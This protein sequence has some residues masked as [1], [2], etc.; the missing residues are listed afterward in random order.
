M[1]S[2]QQASSSTES[3]NLQSEI[4]RLEK[5]TERL[6]KENSKSVAQIEDWKRKANELDEQISFLSGAKT[7][8]D[9][10]KAKNAKLVEEINALK[11][12]KN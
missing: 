5:E 4:D 3:A 11:K 9:S 7:E 1:K 8:G 10:E 2:A 6:E 12:G